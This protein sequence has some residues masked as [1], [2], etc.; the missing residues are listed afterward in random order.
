[1]AEVAQLGEQVG[2]GMEKV[3]DPRGI[4]EVAKASVDS[5]VG[6]PCSQCGEPVSALVGFG[7]DSSDMDP[8]KF[9]HRMR[10][11]HHFLVCL[12]ELPTPCWDLKSTG[13]LLL[14]FSAQQNSCHLI[15][16]EQG[17]LLGTFCF[18]VHSSTP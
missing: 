9:S 12:G 1:M 10:I 3:N 8:W 2:P 11:Y 15:L 18:L 6:L 14:L 17:P 5:G 16:L 4:G 7:R 13:P